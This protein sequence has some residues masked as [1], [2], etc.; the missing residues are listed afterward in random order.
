[1]ATTISCPLP[2]N[3]SPLS[4]N[5]FMFNVTKLPE[6]SFFC[7]QIQLP[8]ITLGEPEFANPFSKQPVPGETLTYDQ[9]TIQFI[10]DSEMKNYKAIYNWIIALG[11]PQSYQQYINL[12]Q[13]DTLNY[14]ELAKNYSDATLQILSANNETGHT[15]QF[16]DVF[17]TTI[18][19]L[20]FMST[21]TD[22]QYL[23]GNATFRFG[24][25][26]FL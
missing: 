21:A 24:Y 9:L 17:P 20:Q 8:S 23:T 22:V 3:L 16:T 25:Y 5:G 2:S 12:V 15:I 19:S 7:Q 4:P 6:L 18:E 11:F 1:M 26:K 13:G 10:V 14:S